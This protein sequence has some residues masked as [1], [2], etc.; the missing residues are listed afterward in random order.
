MI[1]KV[2]NPAL[3]PSSCVWDKLRRYFSHEQDPIPPLSKRSSFDGPAGK[4]NESIGNYDGSP[5]NLSICSFATSSTT[6]S[7]FEEN[8]K[9]IGK[10]LPSGLGID[11]LALSGSSVASDE[12]I[13]GNNSKHSATNPFQQEVLSPLSLLQVPSITTKMSRL[14]SNPSSTISSKTSCDDLDKKIYND[15]I[16]S[17]HKSTSRFDFAQGNQT[18]NFEE[19][20]DFNELIHTPEVSNHSGKDQATLFKSSKRLFEDSSPTVKETSGK[21]FQ[22]SFPVQEASETTG[23]QAIMGYLESSILKKNSGGE[24]VKR[25]PVN[26]GVISLKPCSLNPK[27]ENGHFGRISNPMKSIIRISQ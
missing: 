17:Q 7:H 10:L 27:V 1:R 8:E 2:N 14:P 26:S 12:E 24:P 16:S 4:T 18:Q 9:S 23:F 15:L 19:L 11:E 22:Q 21:E 5:V 13:D 20:I 3:P 25:A 6:T